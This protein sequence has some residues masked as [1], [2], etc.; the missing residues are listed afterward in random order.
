MFRSRR[1]TY[2]E[3]TAPPNHLRACLSWRRSG[4]GRQDSSPAS[5]VR[6]SRR[7]VGE[8]E[9]RFGHGFRRADMEPEA[10]HAH[11][12]KTLRFHRLVEQTV[13]REGSAGAAVEHARMD[14]RRA[15]IGEGDDLALAAPIEL[16]G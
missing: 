3:R 11:A 8:G 5:R 15:G 4:T 1:G 2:H 13:Q 16:A 6:I 12:G 7:A 10:I 9:F 14:N